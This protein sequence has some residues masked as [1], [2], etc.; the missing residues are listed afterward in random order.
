[1]R[2]LE[3]IIRTLP[4]KSTVT[5]INIGTF[6]TLVKSRQ[7]G[8]SS[9]F[10]DPCTGSSAAWVRGAGELIGRKARE[11][12]RLS[13]SDRLLESSLGVAALNSALDLTGFN[14]HSLNAADLIL[15][16]GRGKKVVIIGNF[17]FV[18]KIE[19]HLEELRII[20]REPGEA[21]DGVREA[22]KYLPGAAVAAI[23]GSSFI[24]KTTESLLALC[25]RA[26]TIVL[27]PSTPFSR[28]LFGYGVDAIS[29]SLVDKPR[30][31]LPYIRQGA[32]FRRIEGLKLLTVF[33]E[34]DEAQGTD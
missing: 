8:I 12:A 32:S 22:E 28:V 3:D 9:T 27:G 34:D 10:R 2:L 25:P 19:P 7:W 31:A 24:T 1:M 16:K 15:E 14:F 13:L 6:D 17:P 20:H 26:Y 21:E 30:R 11:L 33:R 23:T 29:G 18:K 4:D 5:E